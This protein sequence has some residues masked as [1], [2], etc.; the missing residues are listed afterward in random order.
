MHGVPL[1]ILVLSLFVPRITLAI[2][3]L[4]HQVPHG[5]L[6]DLA[7]L[8][9]WAFVPRVLMLLYIYVNMGFGPWFVAHLIAL[10]L[11]WGGSGKQ[12]SDRWN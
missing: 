8:L 9:M 12:A 7:A 5:N 2:A 6:P 10:I 3:F 4:D 11:V 1:W